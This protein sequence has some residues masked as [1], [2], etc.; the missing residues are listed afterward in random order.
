[1]VGVAFV[2]PKA[3]T[4]ADAKF[5]PVI[6]I[7]VPGA[8]EVGATLEIVGG[9]DCDPLYVNPLA[10]LADRL[11]GF[12]TVTVARPA[13]LGGVTAWICVA[14]STVTLVAEVLPNSNRAPARKFVPVIVTLVPPAVG[15]L[16]G[17]M[18]LTVGV[19][20]L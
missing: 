7:C 16:F 2:L 1:V 12:S 18:L 20:A 10:R 9:L 3:T 13:A 19:E 4:S 14:L 11:P 17:E 8:P 5:V 15:P 6:V